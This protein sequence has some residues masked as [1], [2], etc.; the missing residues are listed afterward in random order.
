MAITQEQR[1]KLAAGLMRMLELQEKQA[2]LVRAAIS[3]LTQAEWHPAVRAN[4]NQSL[5]TRSNG[6]AVAQ[7]HRTREAP[8]KHGAWQEH[9]PLDEAARPP[10]QLAA[11]FLKSL[12]YTCPGPA[13]RVSL[14]RSTPH[15][16]NVHGHFPDVPR[17]VSS[18]E[19]AA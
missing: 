16:P 4:Q 14:G 6:K 19:T 3:L 13:Q 5:T 10:P 15:K 8:P 7:G 18:G 1:A 12:K 2:T 9:M 17:C 11:P